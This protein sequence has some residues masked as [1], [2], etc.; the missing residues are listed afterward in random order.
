[1]AH[2]LTVGYDRY[3]MHSRTL[4]L[5]HAGFIVD[6][7]FNLKSALALLKSDSIDVL[8]LCHTVSK[9]EQSRLIAAVRAARRALPIICIETANYRLSEEGCISSQNDP[10]NLVHS[11]RAAIH[12]PPS[13]A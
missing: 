12:V 11:V 13:S 10:E 5:Q 6:Q 3:L 7:A 1:M 2:L 8:I 4:L 9:Q